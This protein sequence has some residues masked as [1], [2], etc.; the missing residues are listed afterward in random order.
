[1]YKNPGP[2]PPAADGHGRGP[3]PSAADRHGRIRINILF[4]KTW[5][6]QI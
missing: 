6:F 3:P 4:Q 1:M 2:P 5:N